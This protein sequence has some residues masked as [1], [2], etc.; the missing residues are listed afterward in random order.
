MADVRQR[1]IERE[2]AVTQDPVEQARQRIALVRFLESR[3]EPAAAASVME[4]LY[5]ER[6]QVLGVVRATVDYYTRNQQPQEAIRVL[7]ASAGRANDAYRD[8]FTLEAARLATGAHDFARARELLQPLLQRDPYR[9]EY[10]AAMGDTYLQ[11]GDDKNFRDFEL[12]SIQAL[13]TSPLAP[14]ER[15][16]RIAAMRR[17]LVP[18]LTRLKD[19]AGAVD[20]YIDVIN[21]FPEDER[22]IKEASLF[23]SRHA[24][25]DRIAGFYRKTI[26]DSPKDYRWP[27]VLARVETVLE[28]FPAA[29]S[30]YDAALKARP[31]RKDLLEYRETL[32][33]RTLEFDRAI[34]SCQTLYELSYHDPQWM[35]RSAT[36]KARLGHRE[37]AVHDLRAAEIGERNETVQTLMTVAQQLDLWNYTREAVD[38]AERARK[39]AGPKGIL[40]EGFNSALWDRIMV[41]GRRFDDVLAQSAV[42]P[43]AGAAVRDYYTPEEKA[44]IE[45]AVRKSAMKDKLVFAESAEFTQLE[46]DLLEAQLAKPDPQVERKLVALEI[47]RARFAELGVSMEAYAARNAG[48]PWWATVR[49]WRPRMH[50]GRRGIARPNCACL[51]NCTSSVICRTA[52]LRFSI[53]R[54]GNRSSRWRGEV[55]PRRPSLFGQK[56]FRLR[57]RHCSLVARLVSGLD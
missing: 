35:Y 19:F 52:I 41:R 45:T 15:A 9:S 12:A 55:I 27:M 30:A 7:M 46:S 5:R 39:L 57:N 53:G 18:A 11:A 4:V 3:K 37:D 22:L 29:I 13:P 28:D 2:I 51:V 50:G 6:P 33:E 25:G 31:D 10:L 14:V 49:F 38:Y 48:I 17:D 8:Q 21:A 1:A 43:E 47:S 42:Q 56:T 32:E 24:L 16:A 26:G 40:T 54:I 23:A 36:L 44:S 20:Q 34:A